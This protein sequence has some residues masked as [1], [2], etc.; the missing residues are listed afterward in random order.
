MLAEKLL[1]LDKEVCFGN[2]LCSFNAIKFNSKYLYYYLKS[3]TFALFFKSR[4]NGI[5]GGVSI[6]K[7]KTILIPFPPLAEQKRIVEKIEK[8]FSLIDETTK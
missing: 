7:L 1:F 5:I 8:L 3:V 6:L 2:K 4:V